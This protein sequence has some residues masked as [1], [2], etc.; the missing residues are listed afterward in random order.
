MT[1]YRL[2]TENQ[3]PSFPSKDIA[4]FRSGI[5][6]FASSYIYLSFPSQRPYPFKN[7]MAS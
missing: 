6:A 2:R 3:L 4:N 5:N 7:S 1:L